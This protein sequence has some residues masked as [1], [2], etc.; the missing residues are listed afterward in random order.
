MMRCWSQSSEGLKGHS[1]KAG[2][3]NRLCHQEAAKASLKRNRE[4]VL[5][6]V[7]SAGDFL[8][9]ADGV[10]RLMRR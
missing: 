8:G 5:A 6:G 10:A 7:A 1:Q 2:Q 9:N 3:R 4:A